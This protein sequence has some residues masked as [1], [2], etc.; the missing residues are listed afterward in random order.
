VLVEVHLE[1]PLAAAVAPIPVAI[2]PVLDNFL[3][4]EILSATLAEFLACFAMGDIVTTWHDLPAG[5]ASIQG[6]ADTL[7]MSDFV[8]LV[9]RFVADV[10]LPPVAGCA[11][12]LNFLP[13]KRLRATMAA[14]FALAYPEVGVSVNPGHDFVAGFALIEVATNSLATRLLLMS[15][16]TFST[17]SAR[18]P[19]APCP[20]IMEFLWKKRFVALPACLLLPGPV[21]AGC[22]VII[23]DVKGEASPA[24]PT[25]F[26]RVVGQAAFAMS[27]DVHQKNLARFAI[28]ATGIQAILEV[29][30]VIRRVALVVAFVAC[31]L[32]TLTLR[33]RL[34]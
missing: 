6:A 11:M 16:H 19:V 23:D 27:L 29:V 3:S 4:G 32:L 17:D 33:L 18:I 28:L 31:L 22:M 8:V 24:F 12:K 2:F 13:R 14:F 9:H 34:S 20:M 25:S 10:A 7:Q 15:G 5:S 1:Y 26:R 21:F 30:L